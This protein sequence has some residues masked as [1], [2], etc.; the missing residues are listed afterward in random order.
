MRSEGSVAG[1]RLLIVTPMRNEAAHVK[2]LFDGMSAQ[3]RPPD[4]WVIVDDGS[5]DATLG[6]VGELAPTLPYVRLAASP[7]LTVTPRDGLATA[8]DARAF[9]VGLRSAGATTW[10]FIGKI[11]GDI[12]LPRDYFEALLSRFASRPNLGMASGDLVEPTASGEWKRIPIPAHHVP[13]ALKLYRADCLA[14]IGGVPEFLGWDTLDEMYARLHGYETRSFHDLIARHHRP[15]GAANGLLR[16]RAR[17]GACAWVAHYPLYWVVLRALK[18]SC[19][20]PVGLSGVAFLAGYVDSALRRRS[21]PDDP[22][23]RAHVRHELRSRLTHRRGE[24]HAGVARGP[25]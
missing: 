7:Q 10:D 20:R 19:K 14:A 3:T 22:A 1:E 16:G 17:H 15:T 25:Q 13:G 8:A 18:V 23:L 9:N 21:R 2:R 6:L 5:T 12:Q 24:S 11:D 4:R